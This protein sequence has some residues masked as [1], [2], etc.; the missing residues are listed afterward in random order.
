[1]RLISSA[2]T[3]GD[4]DGDGWKEIL[5]GGDTFNNFKG[6][7]RVVSGRNGRILLERKGDGKKIPTA[8]GRSC[9]GLPDI[10]GDGLQDFAVSATADAFTYGQVLFFS[11]KDGATL[12][13]IQSPVKSSNFGASLALLRGPKSLGFPLLVVGAPQERVKPITHGAVYLFSLKTKKQVF[14]SVGTLGIL[15][16]YGIHVVNVGDT[17][18]DNVDDYAI[19]ATQSGKFPGEG[20]YV[21]LRSGKTKKLL[22]RWK[23]DSQGDS[24]GNSLAALGDV[25]GDGIGDLL[26]GA[27]SALRE[28]GYARVFSCG[29]GTVIRTHI[30]SKWAQSFFGFA[31][32][33]VGDADGD[34]R[35]DYLISQ[36]DPWVGH[37]T[38][39]VFL[40]SGKTGKMIHEYGPP[41]LIS[42]YG[43]TLAP[44]GDLNRDGV[45]EFFLG[46]GGTMFEGVTEVTSVRPLSFSADTNTLSLS[47]GGKQNF[48]LDAGPKNGGKY[49]WIL[50]STS[51]ILPGMWIQGRWLPLN[52]DAY[53][54]LTLFQPGSFAKPSFGLLDQ[55]GKSK[56]AFVLPPGLPGRLKGLVLD[57]AFLVMQ[58]KT[59]S[60]DFTSLPVPLLLGK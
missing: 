14:K 58:P 50:G 30:G 46:Y 37:N 28:K 32:S 38:G 51:G 11:G 27:D 57:H 13:R 54:G 41:P 10:N 48:W 6:I 22:F 52:P 15:D 60:L 17:D 33:G 49:F 45:P 36:P 20:G 25:D 31:V 2:K 43:W 9:L 53:F 18:G 7:F 19:A 3:L 26:A 34:G 23:G 55:A 59:L 5:V 8:L 47:Q 24:M 29:K 44:A 12:G 42:S 35:A 1:M 56:A 16:T 21:E 4:L 40:Y 39:A